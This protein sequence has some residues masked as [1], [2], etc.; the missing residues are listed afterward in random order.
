MSLSRSRLETPAREA[1]HLRHP[2]VIAIVSSQPRERTAFAALSES[3]GWPTTEC[4]SI[5]AAVR[6]LQHSAPKVM[7]VRHRLA[8]GY[9]DEVLAAAGPASATKFIVLIPAGSTATLEA[10]QLALGADCVQRD[11][12]RT[13]VLAE[14]LAKYV[15]AAAAKNAGAARVAPKT[16]PFAGAT[17]QPSARTLTRE[18]R[19]VELTPREVALIQALVHPQGE[20]TTYETLYHEILGRRFRGDTSNMRV[21]LGKLIKSAA[22]LD[23]DLRHWIEVVPKLGYRYRRPRRA[24]LRIAQPTQRDLSAA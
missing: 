22:E 1:V 10:R 5:R 8:D 3:R 7:L 4:D 24:A 19:A 15:K 6:L 11:P 17:L 20:L 21:L 23:V 16:I 18:G 9:S 13:E 14:Y 12:V 2:I